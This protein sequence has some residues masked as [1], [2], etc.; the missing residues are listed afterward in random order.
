MNTCFIVETKGESKMDCHVL[1]TLDLFMYQ[2]H[3]SNPEH[4]APTR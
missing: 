2:G 3:P 4:P 1:P